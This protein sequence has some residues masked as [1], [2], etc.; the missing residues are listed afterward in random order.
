[1]ATRVPQ[2]RAS[3]RAELECEAT[4][5]RGRGGAVVCRTQDLGPGGMRVATERPLKPD[6]QLV[7]E[8]VLSDGSRVTG[9][10]HVLR[11][12][13]YRCYALRFERLAPGGAERLRALPAD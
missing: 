13:S 1:M 4:L 3:P 6:E 5:S 8:V 7:F 12:H 11:E 2:R 10:A 9:V